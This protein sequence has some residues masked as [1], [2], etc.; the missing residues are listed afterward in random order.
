MFAAWGTSGQC[1]AYAK[2]LRGTGLE[3]A[4]PLAVL[5]IYF[6]ERIPKTCS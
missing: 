2:Y 6:Y 1:G 5:D 3:A 4:L